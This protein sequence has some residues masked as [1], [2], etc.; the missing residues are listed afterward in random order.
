MRNPLLSCPLKSRNINVDTVFVILGVK[1]DIQ[2]DDGDEEGAGGEDDVDG[3][4]FLVG[5]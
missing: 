1:K 3:C 5:V 2:E 4:H